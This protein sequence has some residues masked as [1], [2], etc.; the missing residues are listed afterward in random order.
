MAMI[1]WRLSRI[2]RG[3][4]PWLSLSLALV[5]AFLAVRPASPHS[6]PL[7]DREIIGGSAHIV[8]GV[9]RETRVHWN[10]RH[11]LILTDYT[12]AVEDQLK[13]KAARSIEVSV[14]G[15]TLDG[16]TQDTCLSV[17]LTKGARYL[18]FLGDLEHP[19]VEP[20]TGVWQG[21]FREIEGRGG[22]RFIAAGDTSL[23]LK[24]DGAEVEFSTFVETL[25]ALVAEVEAEPKSQERRTAPADL[26]AKRYDPAA[27]ASRSSATTEPFAQPAV[28]APP[29]PLG[30]AAEVLAGEAPAGQPGFSGQRRPD[31]GKY[32]YQG[33]PPAPIIFDPLPLAW[34]WSPYDQ[35]Q[36]AYW[37]LYAKNLF[38]VYTT[39]SG[40]WRFGNGRFELTGFPS[41]AQMIQQFGQG[42][43]ATTLGI[44]WTRS[45]SGQ[46][47][48]ADVALN[49]AVSWT[50]DTRIATESS[51]SL[52]GF[53]QTMLHEVGHA[54]GL[55]HPWET[56]DVWWDSVMNYSPK[57]YRSPVL[58]TDDT[59][60]AR[61]AYPGIALRD[62]AVGVYTTRDTVGSNNPTYVPVRTSPAS[63][64]PGQRFTLTGRLKIE[65]TGSTSI[66][67]PTIEIY[68]TPRRND[69]T[70]AIF[71]KSLR[72]NTTLPTFYTYFIDAGS[73]QLPATTRAGRYY[74]AIY[75]RDTT[76]AVQSNNSAWAPGI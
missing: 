66:A 43:G 41:N 64:S 46:I 68:F 55:K 6:L 71:L 24:A 45:V 57:A 59:T 14:T 32:V 13:G 65:N 34:V 48:E 67:N 3:R 39:P 40:T 49:P 20:V 23:A 36:M 31:A 42:W 35:N 11:N 75:L 10:D 2:R 7:T 9:V 18:L 56:Q 51:S 19:T 5:L 53:Q 38:R 70:G 33:R 30:R 29:P 37:N 15:G 50:L 4:R 8:V 12:L 63:L 44:T 73:L 17:R 69:W 58:W 1:D 28:D 74:L 27:G 52:W 21:V 61:A 60:A 62:A 26:P 54:F 22:K 76:D 25:R 47:V 16:E 72:L